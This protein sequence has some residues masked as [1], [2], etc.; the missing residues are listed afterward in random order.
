MSIHENL[1][2][3]NKI[4]SCSKWTSGVKLHTSFVK[5]GC[6]IY[7][8]FPRSYKSDLPKYEHI[9]KDFRESLWLWDNESPLYMQMWIKNDKVRIKVMT[10]FPSVVLG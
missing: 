8:C 7:Y 2:S 1:T 9:S 5:F 4:R 6:S 3:G 10:D